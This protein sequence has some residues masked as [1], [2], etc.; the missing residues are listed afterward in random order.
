MYPVKTL[1]AWSREE[2]SFPP[3]KKFQILCL[4]LV[5]GGVFGFIY[6]T[7]FYRID[8]GYFVKRSSTWGP[9]IPIYGYGGLLIFLTCWKL[10]RHPA[11]VF[12]VSGGVCGELEFL[13]GYM[14]W[15]LWGMRAW[16]YNTEIWNWG[17]IGGYVCLRSVLFFAA[18]GLMLIY[19]ILPGLQKLCAVLPKKLFGAAAFTLAG[20][21]L[22]DIVLRQ[23]LHVGM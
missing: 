18:S 16:D 19:L 23:M 15:H 3:R 21:F 9:W 14:L 17:N 7:I 5:M 20:L 11:A 13:M 8:L 22:L 12:F 4:L 2:H 6:E 1:Q 10:R